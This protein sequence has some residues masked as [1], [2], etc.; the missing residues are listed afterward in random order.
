MVRD[1][2]FLQQK[3]EPA[4]EADA[5]VIVDLM[6][7][8]KANLDRCVGMAANMIGVKKQIIV[9]AAGPFVFPMVNPVITKKSGKYETEESCLSLDGVRPCVRYDEIEVDFLDQNFK[10][11]HGKYSGFTAQI[12]QHEIQ[13]FSGELI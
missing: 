3:S 1:E 4:T 11:Q 7:T 6:D 13:H 10:P 5:Q 8:L 12:I 2:F 9:V